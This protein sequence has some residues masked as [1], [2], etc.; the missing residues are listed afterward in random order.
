MV[1][2]RS[3]SDR[4]TDELRQAILTHEFRPGDRLAAE[5]LTGRFS[6]SA[7]PLRE[8]FA[9][10]AGEGLVIYVPQRGARVAPVSL[11]EMEEI[12][13]LRTLLEPM[14]IERSASARNEAWADELRELYDEMQA[15]GGSSVASLIPADYSAYEDIHVAF[16]KKT[17]ELCGSRWLRRISETLIDHSRRFRQV[18][19]P[20]RVESGSIETEHRLIFEACNEFDGPR[21]ASRHLEH[22]EN[23]RVAIRQLAQRAQSADAD[24]VSGIDH[25]STGV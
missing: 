19:I 13:E 24:D 3:L 8:A 9:R 17:L 10:L 11:Q 23:T 16:H 21:A 1:D 4:V 7:T 15:A 14:A 22:M 25:L 18:S 5:T 12:Y 2:S 6:A 20:I